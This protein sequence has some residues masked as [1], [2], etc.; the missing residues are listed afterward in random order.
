MPESDAFHKT[1]GRKLMFT[2]EKEEK[3]GVRTAEGAQSTEKKGRE[4]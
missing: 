2:T 3:R 4:T 1:L